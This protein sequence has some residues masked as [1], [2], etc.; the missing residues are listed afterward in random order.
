M[1][2]LFTCEQAISFY[3]LFVS[4]D[5]P[6]I[7]E[8]FLSILPKNQDW[9]WVLGT[10]GDALIESSCRPHIFATDGWMEHEYIS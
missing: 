8:A 9:E 5:F 6:K 3:V 4:I 1:R 2:V 7:G 10:I